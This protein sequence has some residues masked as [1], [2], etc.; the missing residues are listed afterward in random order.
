[1]PWQ[2]TDND[3]RIVRD[4]AKRVAEIAG[5]PVQDERR[6]LWLRQNALDPVRPL[7]FVSPEG[8]WVE[9]VPEESLQCETGHARGIE[10]SLRRRIY[11]QEHFRDDQVC[12][13]LWGV[14]YAVTNT[15]WGVAERIRRPEAQRGA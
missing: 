14:S 6:E 11:A 12:D 15:G 4:L 9:L 3:R 10:M 1:M 8:S 13:D 2:I 7:V 5:D